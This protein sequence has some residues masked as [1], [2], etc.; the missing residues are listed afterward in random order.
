MMV[1][2]GT[3]YLLPLAAEYEK[4]AANNNGSDACP[5]GEVDR[6]L[7]LDREFDR[8]N[9][10]GRVFLGVRKAAIGKHEHASDHQQDGDDLG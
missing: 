6:L 1:T 2:C 3:W 8:P 5:N 9:F 10:D 4:Q 7:L